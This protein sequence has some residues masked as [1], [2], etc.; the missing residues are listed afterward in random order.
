MKCLESQQQG[1][2]D[3]WEHLK[4]QHFWGNQELHRDEVKPG[5]FDRYRESPFKPNIFPVSQPRSPSTERKEHFQETLC[6][7]SEEVEGSLRAETGGQQPRPRSNSFGEKLFALSFL[8]SLCSSGAS[9]LLPFGLWGLRSLA[10]EKCLH[11][12]WHLVRLC[13]VSFTVLTEG[14]CACSNA[15]Q[16]WRVWCPWPPSPLPALGSTLTPSLPS[17]PSSGP[18]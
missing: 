4:Q 13:T 18:S 9:C 15:G 17:T 11:T 6:W 5:L 1:K 12:P 10:N 16:W 8:S 3:I 14:G 2:T 7:K